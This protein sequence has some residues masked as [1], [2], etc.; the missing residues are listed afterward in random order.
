MATEIFAKSV[1]ASSTAL[2]PTL[3]SIHMRLPRFILAELNTHRIKSKN[4]RS[5]RAV[6]IPTMLKEVIENPVIPI[7]WG[8]AQKGM[9]AYE[10]NNRPI[11]IEQMDEFGNEFT[12]EISNE[13]A[14]LHARDAA[15]EWA[16]KFYEA[17]YHKQVVNRLLEPFM[18]VDSLVSSTTWANFTWL[19]DHHAAEP[20]IQELARCVIKVL[21][22][23]V[24]VV[25]DP[26]HWHLPYI[27]DGDYGQVVEHLRDGSRAYILPE[28][29]IEALKQVS[30]ARCARISYKP[31]DGNATIAAELERFK[32]LIESDRVHA[33]PV[34]HQATPDQKSLFRKQVLRNPDMAKYPDDEWETVS[35]GYDYNNPQLHGNFQ[36]WIQF[37]KTIPNEAVW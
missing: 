13:S 30:A 20:H 22:E 11:K 24:P 6:P 21:E 25:K 33:S 4:S 15:V 7:H 3:H 36:G 8:L 34:E 10:Q 16:T 17:G 5:S 27:Q 31:F 26:G 35:E 12:V 2:S 1:L 37:R 9:Q 18:H 28:V 19:R 29:A 23:T 14:W 32:S